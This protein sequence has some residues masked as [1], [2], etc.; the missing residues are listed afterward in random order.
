M[1]VGQA[2]VAA[3]ITLPGQSVVTVGNTKVMIIREL[4]KGG[5]GTV[6][7]A[8]DVEPQAGRGGVRK[9]ALKQMLCQSREQLEDAHD[10]LRAL[11]MFRGHDYIIHLLDHNSLKHPPKSHTQGMTSGRNVQFLFPLYPLGTVWDLIEKALAGG[12]GSEKVD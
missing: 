3:G 1:E 7:L 6:Y 10:E 2:A 9:Y 5:F 8:Q 11:Q 4:A 12:G